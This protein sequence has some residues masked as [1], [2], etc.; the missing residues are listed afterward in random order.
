M[1]DIDYFDKNSQ[2][3]NEEFDNN[4]IYSS[5]D[6]EEDKNI[7]IDFE[8]MRNYES[9]LN[10]K[11]NY[12]VSVNPPP[13]FIRKFVQTKI[14]PNSLYKARYKEEKYLFKKFF[15]GCRPKTYLDFLRRPDKNLIR[16]LTENANIPSHREKKSSSLRYSKKHAIRQQEYNADFLEDMRELEEL[17]QEE[18]YKSQ[19]IKMSRLID[20]CITNE[21]LEK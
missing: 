1:F 16:K 4:S 15:A 5:Y 7:F 9:D 10:F 8:Q 21:Y 11:L 2:K 18:K 12:G 17:Y 6:S 20:A 13:N 3:S 19:T 14:D